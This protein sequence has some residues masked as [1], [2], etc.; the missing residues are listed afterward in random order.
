VRAW[1][2]RV[3]RLGHEPGDNLAEETTAEQRLAMVWDLTL[4][5]WALTGRP[6]P[7]YSRENLPARIL[8]LQ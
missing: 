3:F 1:S 8:R 7:S 6:L 5:M 2:A 4:R